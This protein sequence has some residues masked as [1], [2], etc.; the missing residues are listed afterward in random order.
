MPF[1]PGIIYLAT[2]LPRLLVPP[3][4]VYCLKFAAE[5][6]LGSIIPTWLTS[7]AYILSGPAFLAL[8][9]QYR[10][11]CV[12][13]QAAA[14]GAVLPPALPGSIGG[15][16]MLFAKVKDM[17]PAEPLASFMLE[18]GYTLTIRFL[19]QS[20][21]MT[22]EPENIKAILA[23]SFPDFEKGPEFQR[24]MEPLLGTGI[25]AADVSSF[26]FRS[27][28]VNTCVSRFHRQ[29]TRPFFHR[30][31]ISDFDNFDS[32]ATNAIAQFKARLKEGCAAD[33]Q[34]M[35]ARFTMDTASSFLFGKD[36]RSLDAGLPY[37]H[38]FPPP[39]SSSEPTS[40]FSSSNTTQ[41]T[42]ASTAFANAFQSAQTITALRTRLNTHWPLAEFWKDDLVE[43][44]RVVREFLD[45]ILKE[46]VEK[47]RG[48]EEKLHNVNSVED[49]QVL[50]GETLL[51]HLV[52]YTD[53]PII[54][55]DEI[56][57]ITAAG[58]DTTAALLT[59]TVYMLAEHPKVLSKLRDEIFREIGPTA[60]PTYDNF[61]DMKY[62]RAVLNGVFSIFFARHRLTTSF[63][64]K[65]C[66]YIRLPFNVR[67]ALKPTV[68][69]S[70][71]KG[72][73]P[74]YVPAGTRCGFSTILMHRH[75]DLW[76][77][78]ALQFDPERF[79]DERLHKYLTPNPFIFLPFNGGP[80][81]CLGQQFA[82]HEASFFLVRLLQTFSAISLDPDAQPPDARP[83]AK[84][85]TDEKMV[86]TGWT[87]H[88]KI[89]PRSHLTMFVYGGL[90]VRM[91]EAG[92]KDEGKQ[93]R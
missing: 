66:G 54:L 15:L 45:P 8:L 26:I 10:D 84:W 85:K 3:L 93:A 38:N 80:R 11:Y 76:G 29:M 56:L 25:F 48:K 53:D 9:V 12:R 4:F 58:R 81:I 46:A 86:K 90:W 68:F 50:E 88:E 36:V 89:R 57:N 43:P 69:H 22:A 49:R 67:T 59:F 35:V 52:N 92:H 70:N 73:P 13:S 24:L 16:H 40:S 65:H 63:M 82:Y 31:R 1:P 61:R 30:E 34:D 17:Y 44:M 32:H 41:T 2:H 21:I 42:H 51:D 64:K 83:P 27:V 18:K 71:I 55:R 39:F 37:P 47:N 79:L 91:E 72:S 6:Y 19:F 28:L 7:L 77:P 78:D 87:P 62:L 74:L 20:R 23:T 75:T 5:S 14:H 33:F 60:R